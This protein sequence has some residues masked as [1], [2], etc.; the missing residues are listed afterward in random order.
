MDNNKHLIYWTAGL[1]IFA[2][3]THVIDA[4]DHLAEWWGYG[5]FFLIVATFQF[6]Y[7]FALFIRPWR[8]DG[9]GNLR[10]NADRYGRPFF[11]LGTTLTGAVIVV[12]IVTR[13]TGMPFFGR[14][15]GVEPV[16]ALSLVP[17]LA[18]VP[19]LYCQAVLL[20]RTRNQSAKVA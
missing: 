3:V 13:T 4:P 7:G 20:H 17:I 11:I 6:F 8:F 10:Q 16:T 5:T 9:E 19:L 2:L 14:D 15:A 1:S 18:C 12:Y